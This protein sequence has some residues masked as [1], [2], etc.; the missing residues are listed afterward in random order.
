MIDK[1][2]KIKS[3]CN[4]D[5]TDSSKML[6][7]R[8]IREFNKGKSFRINKWERAI[9][10][11]NDD[12]IQDWVIFE[13]VILICIK[14]HTSEIEPELIYED[15]KVIGV[16]SSYWEIGIINSVPGIEKGQSEGS[17][18]LVNSK[19]IASGKFSSALGSDNISGESIPNE[20]DKL[21]YVTASGYASHAEGAAH[22]IGDYSHAEGGGNTIVDGYKTVP[23]AEGKYS[24]AEGTHTWAKGSAS[25]AE[26]NQTIAEGA[27]SH[28]EGI[29]TKAIGNYSH[30]E[31]H[32]NIT[33][34]ENSHA[35]GY[36]N[37][38]DIS[39]SSSHVE[40]AGNTATK[41]YSHAEGSGNTASGYYSHVEGNKST[42]SGSAAH[43]EGVETTAS[44]T[45]SHAQGFKTI[46]SGPRSSASGW[47]TKATNDSEFAVGKYNNSNSD[48]HF[49]IGIGTSEDD[50]KNAYEIT[51]DGKQYILGVGNYDGKTIDNSVKDL[52]RVIDEKANQSAIPTKLSQLKQ[53]IQVGEQ[54][55]IRVTYASLVSLRDNGKL[56]AG[57]FYRITDYVTTTSQLNT[58]SAN[59]GFDIVVVALA[60]G[61]LS[62]VAYACRRDG[63]D[64]FQG[65]DLE[66]WKI[67]YCLDNDTSRFAWASSSGKGVIYRMID[68]NN[69]DCPY[70][71]KNIQFK[72]TDSLYAEEWTYT[73]HRSLD[74]DW[75]M[76]GARLNSIKPYYNSIQHKY[77]LN[78]IVLYV[79]G[80]Y[81]VYGNTFD[82]NC[83]NIYSYNNFYLNT[84]GK[85]CFGLV[86]A[87]SAYSNKFGN[88]CRDSNF[89]SNFRFNVI[90]PYCRNIQV[91]DFCRTC[92]FNVGCRIVMANDET[93]SS[94][95]SI[96]NY[97]IGSDLS[98]NTIQ[99]S[100]GRNYTT[101]VMKGSD[102][103]IKQF[104]I[105]DLVQ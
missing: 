38:T 49:S 95:N 64:Y 78:N 51:I 22:A 69:N 30:A 59:H 68:E 79:A 66:S 86:F 75:S 28:T 29:L 103:S 102:Q 61:T 9:T 46:A 62:E 27:T 104:C 71:F 31:G 101:Y 80:N 105:A 53:D 98:G 19:G 93:A 50:R 40:G 10:Y 97:I 20:G 74:I 67:W 8:L 45:H 44:G 3:S 1:L 73:F 85:A 34:G 41:P 70:D 57:S 76:G 15:S 48:T 99:V 77:V 11:L 17:A 82:D 60:E 89:G 36:N 37:I 83:H 47:G 92:T 58:R 2:K 24:H 100:R 23:T 14:S 56:V 16:N 7:H 13:N 52:K 55:L 42:A 39:A 5:I 12:F 25:H 87:G 63:D 54:N 91:P 94:N 33:N 65:H 90:N 6:N 84:F 43:A 32:S 4:L 88:D 96:Q 18:I 35:E 81:N 21:E 72:N 26:G